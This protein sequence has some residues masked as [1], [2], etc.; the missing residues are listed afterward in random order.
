M[1]VATR[2]MSPVP[3]FDV[4]AH[5]R[6]FP[7]P[8]RG[9]VHGK[10][11]VYLDSAASAQKPRAVIEAIT[12]AYTEDY[13]NVH[14][15]AYY[16]SERSTVAYEE[17]R[18][19][20]RAF[21]NAGSTAEIVFTKGA[22]EAINLVA[23]SYGRSFIK[24]GDEI[25]LTAVEHHS[26]IVPWDLLRT[27]TGCVLRDCAG[28]GRTASVARRGFRRRHRTTHQAGCHRARIQRARNRSADP[29]GGRSCPC[30]R[31]KDLDRRMSGRCSCRCR[32][33]SA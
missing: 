32:C 25:V 23:A 16:L 10:P 29:R 6:R 24:A 1:T 9:K 31:S 4:D 14:R 27:A 18:E 21:I 15:G 26:N 19:K 28:C 3:N 20:V 17:A 33:P 7:D 22:T 11:L 13:A 12:R 5:P 8:C 2:R 30:G